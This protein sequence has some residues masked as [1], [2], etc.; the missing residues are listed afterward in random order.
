MNKKSRLYEKKKTNER[1]EN[2]V[3]ANQMLVAIIYWRND[4]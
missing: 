3:S 2:E 1:N 4:P